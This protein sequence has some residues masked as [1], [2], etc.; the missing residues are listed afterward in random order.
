MS[1]AANDL[2]GLVQNIEAALDIVRGQ[3]KA[4]GMT[5]LRAELELLVEAKTSAAVGGQLPLVPID[6]GFDGEWSSVQTFGLTITASGAA[7]DLGKVD[8]KDELA[9]GIIAIASAIKK[10]SDHHRQ[11]WVVSNPKVTVNVERELSG[12]LK[13]GVGGGKSSGRTHTIT[14]TFELT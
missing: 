12:S 11:T 9:R 1:D 8:V 3:H 5:L 7:G 10:I 4:L 13:V 14:L 2:I 6:V